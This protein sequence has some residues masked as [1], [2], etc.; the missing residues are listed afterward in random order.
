MSSVEDAV[1]TDVGYWVFS[2]IAYLVFL[3]SH[4]LGHLGAL[5]MRTIVDFAMWL[6]AHKS[7]IPSDICNSIMRRFGLGKG[8]EVLLIM[9]NHIIGIRFDEYRRGLIPSEYIEFLKKWIDSGYCN[10]HSLSNSISKLLYKSEENGIIAYIS[11]RSRHKE[12]MQMIKKCS[13]YSLYDNTGTFWY[14][15]YVNIVNFMRAVLK[16]R[17]DGHLKDAISMRKKT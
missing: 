14:H 6:N 7:E 16:V 10:T 5:P 12:D 2:P 8:F 9:S 15:K 11:E 1:L 3:T 4:A 13:R 17:P